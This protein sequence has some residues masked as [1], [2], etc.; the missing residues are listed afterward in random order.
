MLSA[1]KTLV[2]AFTR[3]VIALVMA[4]SFLA[5]SVWSLNPT[6]ETYRGTSNRI[7]SVALRGPLGNWLAENANRRYD[8]SAN[9][10]HAATQPANFTNFAAL[11]APA[12]MAQSGGGSS[13]TVSF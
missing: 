2:G 12:A 11:N 10:L 8:A 1:P 9:G 7:S 13:T 5:T 3:K 4:Y 6:R